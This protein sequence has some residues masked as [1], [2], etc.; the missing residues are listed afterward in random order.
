M[1]VN[2]LLKKSFFWIFLNLIVFADKKW[3]LS[4]I[5]N[6]KPITRYYFNKLS[7]KITDRP[8]NLDQFIFGAD[9][10]KL[11]RQEA[12]GVL[13]ETFIRCTRKEAEWLAQNKQLHPYFKD[14]MAVL[15]EIV[16]KTD[17]AN[18]VNCVRFCMQSY[19]KIVLVS[20]VG[21]RCN[22]F[23]IIFIHMIQ[24]QDC[25]APCL[26]SPTEKLDLIRQQFRVFASMQTVRIYDELLFNA[27]PMT[28]TLLERFR[29]DA[30]PSV[31]EFRNGIIAL[32][33]CEAKSILLTRFEAIFE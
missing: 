28:L 15:F 24:L 14:V 32:A 4:K 21:F 33:D 22:G 8:M 25:I 29:D 17:N 2:I 13:C 11:S 19:I 30:Q 6:L 20:I 23:I 10:N 12:T 5:A 18:S 1:Q 27:Y 31:T 9:F 16:K 26:T 7:L 3:I